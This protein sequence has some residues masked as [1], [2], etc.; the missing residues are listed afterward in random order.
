[1]LNTCTMLPWLFQEENGMYEPTVYINGNFVPASEARVSVFD[2]G[3]RL[4]DA[5][6]DTTRTFRHRPYLLREHI[7]RLKRSLHYTR[8]DLGMSFEQL[9]HITLEVVER[10]RPLWAENDDVWIHQVVSRGRL[11]TVGTPTVVIMTEPLPFASFA[12][13][14]KLGV[15]LIT[16]SIRHTPPQCVEPRVKTVSRLNLVLA[17]L[18]AQQ[19]DPEAYALLLDLEGNITEYTSGNFFIVRQGCLI[20]PFDRTSLG[21]IARETVLGF[22]E[23]LGIPTREADITPYDA[24]NADEAFITST[25]KCILPVAR[26]NGLHIGT[27]VPGPVTKRLLDTWSARVEVDIVAQALSHLDAAQRQALERQGAQAGKVTVV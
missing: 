5:V 27:S 14:Y 7:E 16:P 3:F 19:A 4:G 1:M 2:R 18:E 8:L 15:S 17:E 9:E 6:F 26:L 20:T 12:R 10:N 24:C 13:Y 22:A 25:S 11:R 21:G 23:E